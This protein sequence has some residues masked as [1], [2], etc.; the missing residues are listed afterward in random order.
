MKIFSNISISISGFDGEEK[1]ELL[2][3]IK[4]LGSKIDEN[5]KRS[6]TFVISKKINTEKC[7]VK[8]L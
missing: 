2:E 4:K 6:T 5:L 3:K 7:L 8:N 1:T